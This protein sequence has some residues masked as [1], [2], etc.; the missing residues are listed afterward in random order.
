MIVADA[1]AAA[2]RAAFARRAVAHGQALDA[3]AQTCLDLYLGPARGRVLAGYL[4]IR[5]E[6][7]P[8]PVM[9]RWATEAPVGVPVIEGSGRPLRFRRWTPGCALVPGRFGVMVPVEGDVLSPEVVIAPLVAFD[10]RG[11]RLGYGGG[12][13]DRTLAALEKR[14]R[15]LAIG[16]AYSGQETIEPL[17]VDDTDQPLGVVATELG[18]RLFT[19][20]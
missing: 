5:T 12:F 18:I 20:P 6:I 19:H 1:K 8:V 10:A 15:V 11:F 13:Y 9:A 7:D 3:A 14:A 16:F 4:P 2:R 17:P